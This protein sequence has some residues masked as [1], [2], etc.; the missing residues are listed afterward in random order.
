[1]SKQIEQDQGTE[2]QRF[3]RMDYD[4]TFPFAQYTSDLVVPD[5]YASFVRDPTSGL[6]GFYTNWYDANILHM[7]QHFLSPMRQLGPACGHRIQKAMLVA[8]PTI[9]IMDLPFVQAYHTNVKDPYVNALGAN[10]L[11]D[12]WLAA[13]SSSRTAAD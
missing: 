6:N 8:S 13:T 3:F 5:E 12:T 10:R 9:N 1:M 2:T 11:E 7:F 4:M